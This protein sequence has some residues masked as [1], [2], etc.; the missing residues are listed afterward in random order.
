MA[1]QERRNREQEVVQAAIDVF[2][3]K[4][5]A[6]ATMQDIADAVG[7][8]KGSL[9]HYI[10]SKEDLLFRIFDESHR[11]SIAIM[12]S[13][14]ALDASPLERLREYVRRF[15]TYYTQNIKRADLY[16]REWRFIDGDLGAEVRARRK[17][18]DEFIRQQ[19]AADQ[20]ATGDQLSKL[21]A[22]GFAACGPVYYGDRDRLNQVIAVTLALG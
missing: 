4:G 10:S 17:V 16:F 14:A 21:P 3:R 19:I 6:A 13:V 15:I 12:E 11:D 5:Y 2:S 22:L 8:L 18:Y 20:Y 7:V 9:Y 1:I